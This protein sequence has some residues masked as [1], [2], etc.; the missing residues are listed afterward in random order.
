[1]LDHGHNYYLVAAAF[2]IVLMAGFTGLSLTQGASSMSVTRRKVAVSMSA[3]ALG[4]GI[5]SMHFVAMLGM[6][7]P[8]RFHYDALTTLISAFV[9]I[10]LTGIALLFVHFGERTGS[11]I[12]LAGVCVALGIV[13]MHYI[14]M[15]GIQDVV[16]IY[17][18][19][20]I[21]V[22]VVAAMALCI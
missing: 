17:S 13:A 3:V 11:R 19:Q 2:A 6:T 7:L 12:T 9:A 20:G 21:I 1:M 15:W 5:W 16:P 14:G 18:V 4:S 10:L 8:V 22:A